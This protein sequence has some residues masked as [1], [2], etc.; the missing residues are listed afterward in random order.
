MHN[1]ARKIRNRGE[2]AENTI[3]RQGIT[4]VSLVEKAV[5]YVN[6]PWKITAKT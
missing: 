6:I 1:N 3:F 2:N 4:G 5:E